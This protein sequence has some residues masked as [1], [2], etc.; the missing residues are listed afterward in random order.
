MIV[1]LL[2]IALSGQV[3]A[4]KSFDAK[5]LQTKLDKAPMQNSIRATN[6]Q[7]EQSIDTGESYA[8]NEIIDDEF[9]PTVEST[10]EPTVVPFA[11]PITFLS[12]DTVFMQGTDS[13]EN[14]T[15][16]RSFC[17]DVLDEGYLDIRSFNE[18]CYDTRV[19]GDAFLRL[20]RTRITGPVVRANDD[21]VPGS[22]TDSRIMMDSTPIGKYCLVAGCYNGGACSYA[23]TIRGV[24]LQWASADSEDDDTMLSTPSTAP[25]RGLFTASP[26]AH[27][28]QNEPWI[29]RTG[30]R[31]M[32]NTDS[33][34]DITTSESY[35]FE[36]E[37]ES[38]LVLRSFDEVCHD[39]LGNGDAMLRL[40]ESVLNGG[41]LAINGK[42]HT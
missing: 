22:C 35:C 39:T 37:V 18:S 40:V 42:K 15:S 2:F 8:Y 20:V 3:A 6:R 34:Q 10:V 21:F 24:S 36:V 11:A 25:T 12:T 28:N 1:W 4:T 14:I 33:A 38:H 27:V 17:F 16:V 41:Y 7:E 30:Q 32:M 31:R 29:M 26:T 9:F 19:F 13:A 23:M 5:H